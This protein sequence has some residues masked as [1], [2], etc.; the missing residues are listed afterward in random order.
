MQRGL[1]AQG[2][3]LRGGGLLRAE[4]A[5]LAHLV[6][7]DVAPARRGLRVVHRVVRRGA[8]HHPGEHRGLRD[9]EPVGR[10]VE[11]GPC[12]R[13][14]AERLVPQV[15]HVEV[16]GE[17]LVLGQ[18][19]VELLGDAG[20]AQLAPE[21]RLGGL[22]L[23]GRGLGRDVLV[24]VLDVLLGERRG[25][26]RRP[27]GPVVDDRADDAARVET[28]FGEEPAVLDGDDRRLHRHR[29]LVGRDD[30]TILVIQVR[31]GRTG[32]V[33]DRG[34][35]RH[36]A[37]EHAGRGVLSTLDGLVREQPQA[38]HQRERDPRDEN[39]RDHRHGQQPH[40]RRHGPQTRSTRTIPTTTRA[41][42]PQ[43]P[44]RAAKDS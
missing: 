29:N 40:L 11:V 36:V 3:C 32:V 14:H 31:N 38:S 16:P 17:D 35:G 12:G 20:L 30:L 27:T 5:L 42:S 8:L 22:E 41:V 43:C 15:H 26:L 1:H 2:R 7:D 39:P 19:V 23:L 28:G 33:G 34:D 4:L 9:R 13:G 21:G 25:A 24:V 37:A 10:G 6:D 44:R 18:R